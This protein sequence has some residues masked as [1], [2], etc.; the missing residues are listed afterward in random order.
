MTP[1]SPTPDIDNDGFNDSSSE[2][3]VLPP[4]PEPSDTRRRCRHCGNLTLLDSDDL[5]SHCRGESVLTFSEVA[6]RVLTGE[7]RQ[8]NRKW[9]IR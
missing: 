5:C 6:A 1:P 7:S 3:V 9:W 4:L 2:V 8:F